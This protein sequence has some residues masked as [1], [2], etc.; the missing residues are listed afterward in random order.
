MA[1]LIEKVAEQ[2]F[3]FQKDGGTVIN[4]PA[5]TCTAIGNLIDFK[6]QNGANIQQQVLITEITVL[7][8]Y[9]STGSFTFT[10]A[11]QLFNK[12]YELGFWWYLQGGTG[13]ADRFDNL[14]D[15]FA[16]FGNDGKV[17][18]VNSAL[19]KLVA[20]PFYNVQNITDLA[21]FPSALVAEKMMVVNSAGTG[22]VFID[23][24]TGTGDPFLNA[25]GWEVYTDSGATV[26]YTGA[27][28][29]FELTNDADTVNDTYKAFGIG[30]SYDGLNNAFDLSAYSLGDSLNVKVSLGIETTAT[31][32][33]LRFDL[34]KAIG[35]GSETTETVYQEVI[36]VISSGNA[37]DFYFN[38]LIDSNDLRT[39]ETKLVF[40]SFDDADIVVDKYEITAVR[41]NINI[42]AIT[43][44]DNTASHLKGEYD[45]I[46]NTPP[47]ADGIGQ[48][49]DYYTLTTAGSRDFGSGS[50]AFGIDDR[51]EYDGFLWF[52]AV[53]NN[54]S[55]GGGGAVD[56]VDSLTGALTTGQIVNSLT[57]K[58]TVVDNDLV[59]GSDSEDSNASVKWKFSTIATYVLNKLGGILWALTTKTTPIDA[60]TIT[61]SDTAD[62]NALK[63][64]S[65]TN[66][67]TNYLKAKADALYQPILVSGTNIKTVNGSSILGSG[68]LAV[69][70]TDNE[71]SIYEILPRPNAL[72]GQGTITILAGTLD[73]IGTIYTNYFTSTIRTRYVSAG[74]AGSSVDIYET[75][76][77][78]EIQK[79]WSAVIKFGF[80]D[81]AFVTDARSFMGFKVGGVI[82]NVNPS[83]LNN[84]LGVGND[85]GEA[86]LQVMHNNNMG[87][88]TKIDLGVNFPSNTSATDLYMAIFTNVRGSGDVTYKIVRLN[89]MDVAI[90][91]ITTELPTT[92][93]AYAPAIYRNNGTTALPVRVSLVKFGVYKDF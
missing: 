18:V 63:K 29:N 76:G 33:K 68:D 80:E 90:G 14:A 74:T 25:Y 56:S 61:I 71:K 84:I 58:V 48:I 50:I 39:A 38:I 6:T 21:D 37:I 43:A 89:T 13:G 59:G 34:V 83:T 67:W 54:Q 69:S 19:N 57:E 86:N 35:T 12:L 49:G 30:N 26:A 91:T 24:P 36:P 15:T 92:G 78:I 88:A 60:D 65:L 51:I 9:G 47:L 82:G 20:T 72:T 2:F 5:P 10:T 40:Y 22:I 77:Q 28:S 16:Y 45:V 93:L 75:F 17:P 81:N 11:I 4:E 44:T 85:I 31:N 3:A 62:S 27:T 70:S 1:F 23:P 66:L 7:D 64:V 79:G 41:R 87:T 32:Q 55:G 8:T 46:T 52:K 42:T 53:D 73:A